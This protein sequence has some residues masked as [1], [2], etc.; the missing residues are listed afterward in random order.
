[1]GYPSFPDDD[2]L[3][4]P[5]D[6]SLLASRAFEVVVEPGLERELRAAGAYA[7]LEQLRAAAEAAT[8]TRS[9]LRDGAMT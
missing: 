7:C 3:R 2:K 8:L 5:V 9:T 6:S 4:A 1:M